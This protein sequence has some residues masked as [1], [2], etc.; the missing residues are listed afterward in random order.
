MTSRCQ[1]GS[2]LKEGNIEI[3]YNRKLNEKS[4][5]G[6]TEFYVENYNDNNQN[7]SNITAKGWIL[8]HNYEE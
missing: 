1:G 2:S 8:F 4:E 6:F 7:P 5:K 3:M